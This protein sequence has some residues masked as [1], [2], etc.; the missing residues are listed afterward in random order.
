MLSARGTEEQPTLAL[1]AWNRNGTAITLCAMGQLP[2]CVQVYHLQVLMV[3]P[4]KIFREVLF[5]V[6]YANY[7]LSR[8]PVYMRRILRTPTQNLPYMYNWN[9]KIRLK[10]Y[11]S[12]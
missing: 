5:S 4:H 2:H 10:K 1:T 9:L 3:V 8:L 11:L 12:I 6:H 7:R